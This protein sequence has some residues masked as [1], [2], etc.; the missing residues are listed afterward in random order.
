MGHFPH[1]ENMSIPTKKGWDIHLTQATF[2]QKKHYVVT[3]Q[4]RHSLSHIRSVFHV[5]SEQKYPFLTIVKRTSVPKW[6]NIQWKTVWNQ[7][8]LAPRHHAFQEYPTL[9]KLLLE[10]GTS[11]MVRAVAKIKDKNSIGRRKELSFKKSPYIIDTRPTSRSSIVRH[12]R[13]DRF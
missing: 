3:R 11:K 8:H 10:I 2:S 1:E 13:A 12:G 9:R 7:I 6:L 5:V 4:E